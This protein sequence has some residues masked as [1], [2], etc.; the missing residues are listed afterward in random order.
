MVTPVFSVTR[1]SVTRHL[2]GAR[3]ARRS[4][5]DISTSPVGVELPVPLLELEQAEHASNAA[6]GAEHGW[7][8]SEPR[9]G[10]LHPHVAMVVAR[11]LAVPEGVALDPGLARHI[12][13]RVDRSCRRA[14]RG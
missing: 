5:I 6:P 14:A 4:W 8:V 11:V 3:R 13:V 7:C 10:E 2:G 12:R 1:C 9:H